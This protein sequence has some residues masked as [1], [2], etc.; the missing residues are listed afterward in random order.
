MNNAELI[1]PL[2]D[3][4]GYQLRRAALVTIA[5]LNDAYAELELTST[6][7]MVLRFAHANPGCTQ[8]DVGRSLG[9]KRTNMVPVVSGLLTR[10]LLERTAAD[11]RS[12]ALYLSSKGV[13]RHR[14]LTEVSVKHEKY[15]FGDLTQ[16]ERQELMQICQTLRRK[17]DAI[18]D[19]T[20][21]VERP[22]AVRSARR[23][24]A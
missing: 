8:S 19:T 21:D 24:R 4:L 11:G 7:A 23:K 12:H 18:T 10:G 17:G 22:S 6:E 14:R 2:D 16:R 1:N 5:L 15:F 13:E 3:Y 20:T 9:V